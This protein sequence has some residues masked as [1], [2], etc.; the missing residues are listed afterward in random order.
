ML[1]NNKTKHKISIPAEDVQGSPA[2]IR[3][4]VRYLCDNIMKD[5]R[6][7]LFVVEGSVY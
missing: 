5:P 2:N 4:L 7:E 3:F 1:F 6:R